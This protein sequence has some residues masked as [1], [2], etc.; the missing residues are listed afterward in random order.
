MVLTTLALVLDHGDGAAMPPVQRVG[1]GVGTGMC[2]AS[3]SVKSLLC[4]CIVSFYSSALIQD[5]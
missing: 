5:T 4:T 2:L 3:L 1:H